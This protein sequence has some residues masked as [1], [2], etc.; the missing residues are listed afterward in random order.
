MGVDLVGMS[1][2]VTNYEAD[3]SRVNGLPVSELSAGN[4]VPYS[5]LRLPSSILGE[6]ADVDSQL[7]A[8]RPV[9]PVL[10]FHGSSDSDV[11]CAE[12]RGFAERLPAFE[13]FEFEN[14]D[15]TFTAPVN[16]KQRDEATVVNREVAAT[17]IAEVLGAKA[18]AKA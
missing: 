4:F 18:R 2:A 16:Q 3:L 17:K 6:M 5:K 13:F 10:F 12:A 1:C 14:M 11:P 15:H 8:V 7:K 9:F